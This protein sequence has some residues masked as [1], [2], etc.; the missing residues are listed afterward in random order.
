MFLVSI[1]LELLRCEEVDVFMYSIRSEQTKKNYIYNL[2]RFVEFIKMRAS[3]F[4]K[5]DTNSIENHIIKYI[6]T[7]R[8][9]NLSYSTILARVSPIISFL[10]LNSIIINKKKVKKFYGEQKLVTD[11]AYTHE[12]I[13]KMLSVA[14][15]KTKVIILIY[16][17]TGIRRSAIIDLKLKHMEKDHGN[18]L[19]KVTVYQGTKDEYF[20]FCTP[21]CAKAIDDY[22]LKRE[23]AGEKITPESYLIR[24]NFDRNNPKSVLNVK[25]INVNTLVDL[26]RGLLLDAGLRS[27]RNSRHE[28]HEKAIFHAFRKYFATTLANS[29]VNQ[30]IKE[31]LMGHSVGLDNSYY[32]P[33]EEKMLSEYMKASGN[34]TIDSSERLERQLQV[35]ESQKSELDQLETKHAREISSMV[36]EVKRIR[37]FNEI[38]DQKLVEVISIINENPKL[39]SIDTYELRDKLRRI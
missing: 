25:R 37:A 1:L 4:L 33:N 39:K 29:D 26:L 22:L 30:L 6:I 28:R 13:I 31:L 9:S 38:L 23:L 2:G 16:A 18:N 10:D 12:D 19:Y 5:L 34:L 11:Q 17:S 8:D 32:R 36:E 24:N 14:N 20:T 35:V 7:M 3:Q 15:F 27:S 21:E